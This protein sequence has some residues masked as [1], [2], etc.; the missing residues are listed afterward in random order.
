GRLCGRLYRR[1]DGSVLTR[2][3]PVGFRATVRRISRVAGAALSAAMS[4]Q[5]A[6][7]QTKSENAPGLVQIAA[8]RSSLA[9]SV[10]DPSG[11]LVPNAQ[12][13]LVNLKSQQ[14]SVG[15]TDSVGTLRLSNL[16]AGTYEITVEFRGLR[17]AH[18][19]VELSAEKT[20]EIQV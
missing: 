10:M 11:A 14:K 16:A 19:V 2:D 18:K 15:V 1:S 4:L 7:A 20:T 6:A 5:V 17:T 8:N 3:C 12:V 13:S 9:L